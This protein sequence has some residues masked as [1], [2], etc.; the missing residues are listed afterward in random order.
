[1]AA[2]VADG[3]LAGRSRTAEYRH[4]HRHRRLM[5][6]RRDRRHRRLVNNAGGSTGQIG[7]RALWYEPGHHRRANRRPI[8]QRRQDTRGTNATLAGRRQDHR[9]IADLP[10]RRQETI[11]YTTTVTLNKTNGTVDT[12]VRMDTIVGAVA[13]RVVVVVAAALRVGRYD[14]NI[15]A[16]SVL[17]VLLLLLLWWWWLVLLLLFLQLKKP[18]RFD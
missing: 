13:Q 9:S 3:P 4:N 15:A 10:D 1:M 2:G 16:Q 18:S 12:V 17:L 5:A 6:G 7:S 8:A 14:R 11:T